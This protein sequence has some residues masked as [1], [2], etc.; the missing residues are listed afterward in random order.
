[1]HSVALALRY[2]F[3]FLLRGCEESERRYNTQLNGVCIVPL[4]YMEFNALKSLNKD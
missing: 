2:S 3:I 4:F 1:M